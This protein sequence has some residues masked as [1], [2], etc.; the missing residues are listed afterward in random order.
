MDLIQLLKNKKAIV[1]QQVILAVDKLIKQTKNKRISQ[2]LAYFKKFCLNGK[3]VRG[4][5]VLIIYDIFKENNLTNTTYPKDFLLLSAFFELMHTALLIHD[6]IVD[7]DN[8]RRGMKTV[9]IYFKYKYRDISH[10][11]VELGKSL[12]LDLG[13]LIYFYCFRLLQKIENKNKAKLIDFMLDIYLKVA[14]GQYNDIL[15]G[16]TS[17]E[18]ETDEIYKVYLNK[19]ASY[20]FVLPISAAL[21][22]LNNKTYK[23]K[24]FIEILETLGV[25]FQITDDLIG[26]L[27][28]ETGK[29][30]GSDIRE[31]KK[32]LIRQYILLDPNLKTELQKYFGNKNLTQDEINFI[33]DKFK[34]SA[35]FIKI[36]NQILKLKN[37]INSKL[38]QTS[39]PKTLKLLILEFIE[40]LTTRS[41]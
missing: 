10:N 31:N 41:N 28:D 33:R 37:N 35:A 21:I 40:F 23:N 22:L 2:D 26:F 38:Q 27:S 29:D 24:N 11:A 6:D 34:N 17:Y 9:H 7:N 8:K 25:L 39:L 18:P 19:T 36:N 12:S 14:D 30:K 5:L 16:Q 32:T 4:G 13:D 15:F 1:D 3:S 20:T